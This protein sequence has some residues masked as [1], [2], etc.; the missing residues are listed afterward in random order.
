MCA[1]VSVSTC[2]LSL[3]RFFFLLFL[4]VWWHAHRRVYIYIRPRARVHRDGA[5]MRGRP[6]GDAAFGERG[7]CV[8]G[9]LHMNITVFAST[10]TPTYCVD[11]NFRIIPVVDTRS[12]FPYVDC[13]ASLH[14]KFKGHPRS[15]GSLLC[16]PEVPPHL[17]GVL[18]ATTTRERTCPGLSAPQWRRRQDTQFHV[19]C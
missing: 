18:H 4:C 10:G 8:P 6:V 7:A 9:P 3:F 1:C 19:R 12:P 13:T 17:D 14:N 15:C 16:R 5:S 11:I 2:T